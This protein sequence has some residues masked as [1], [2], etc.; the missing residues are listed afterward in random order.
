[1][2]Q[3]WLPNGIINLMNLSQECHNSNLLR[4]WQNPRLPSKWNMN[5]LTYLSHFVV[6]KSLTCSIKQ[7]IG[8]EMGKH[9]PIWTNRTQAENFSGL[10]GKRIYQM[11]TLKHI[12]SII[13]DSHLRLWNEPAW[14]RANRMRMAERKDGKCLCPWCH[15][16]VMWSTNSVVYTESWLP[17]VWDNSSVLSFREILFCVLW[18]VNYI[19][20][21]N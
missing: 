19:D 4:I 14:G 5:G 18:K 17:L 7:V 11:W 6:W 1:M 10:L 3:A 20:G 13:A 16:W 21:L 15:Y 12:S 8:L 9:N 2:R